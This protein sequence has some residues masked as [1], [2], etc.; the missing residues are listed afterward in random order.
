MLAEVVGDVRQAQ[1]VVL[2]IRGQGV[3]AGAEPLKMV[4]VLEMAQME[5]GVVVRVQVTAL[6]QHAMVEMVVMVLR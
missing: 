6:V 3:L 1:P 5:L 2:V 4:L